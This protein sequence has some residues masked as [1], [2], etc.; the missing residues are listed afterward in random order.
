MVR[1]DKYLPAVVDSSNA[2]KEKNYDITNK[3]N[4]RKARMI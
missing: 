3:F 4:K 2:D 1:K